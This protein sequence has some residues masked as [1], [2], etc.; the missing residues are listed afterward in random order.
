MT[1]YVIHSARS[2]ADD[3]DFTRFYC[4]RDTS[5]QVGRKSDI[6]PTMKRLYVGCYDEATSIDNVKPPKDSTTGN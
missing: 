5:W 2:L 3:A 6:K 1:S 4:N